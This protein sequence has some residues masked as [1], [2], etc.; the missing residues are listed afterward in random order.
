MSSTEDDSSIPILPSDSPGSSVSTTLQDEYQE[1]L[2]YAVVTPHYD[3]AN[4]PQS[5]A[6]AAHA[7]SGRQRQDELI[8]E[9][10]TGSEATTTT[11]TTEASSSA[12]ALRGKESIQAVQGST[13]DEDISDNGMSQTTGEREPRRRIPDQMT[14]VRSY[15]SGLVATATPETPDSD[16]STLSESDLSRGSGMSPSVDQ[17]LARMEAN[18]DNWSLDLKRNVLAEL[19]QS[20]ILLI[21]RH[22][23]EIRVIKDRH[24]RDIDHLQNEIGNLKELLHTYEVSIERK[25]GVVSN[26][27]RALQRQKERFEMLRT[28]QAWKLRHS[29]DRRETFTSKLAVR[30]RERRQMTKVWGAWHSLIEAKWKQRVEKACQSKAQEVCMSLT[31]DYETR[32]ASL[33]EA[34]ESSRTEVTRLHAER[35]MYEETMKKAFMRGVCALNL[36]AM[37]MFHENEDNGGNSRPKSDDAHRHQLPTSTGAP[38]NPHPV[39][40]HTS[41]PVAGIINTEPQSRTVT[42]QGAT[43]QGT[44]TQSSSGAI[45]KSGSSASRAAHSYKTTKTI[46][47]RVST[48]PDTARSGQSS[49]AS[50]APPMSSVMVERH[51]PVTQQ[52]IGHA[53]ASQYPVTTGVASMSRDSA[54][55]TLQ[56]HAQSYQHVPRQQPSGVAQRK[57]AGQSGRV[58]LTS[59]PN[60]HT[61]KVVH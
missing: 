31:N 49:G 25:D 53:M 36:E 21:E 4:L 46:T 22:R 59:T 23:Q 47:A 15:M 18:L 43:T 10:S 35:D 58:A 20:K 37:T 17:D 14:P 6:Q 52:T 8:F 57:I 55:Q 54:R 45:G 42:S 38:H 30:Q 13:T 27:T 7:F 28:F 2:K 32:L 19:S 61:V 34:L 26:L 40:P 33:N 5:L 11:T 44:V 3:P 24:G 12:E 9:D 48:R 16:A 41:H 51:H 39:A 50:L 56:G 29:E 60:I 1:L